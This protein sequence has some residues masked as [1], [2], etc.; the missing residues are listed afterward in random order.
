MMPVCTF[1]G[2]RDCPET[3][4]DKL[5]KALVELIEAEGVDVFYV[6]NHGAFDAMV[7]RQLREL[8]RC[9]PHIRYAVVLA[10]LPRKRYVTEEADLQDTMLPEG[11]EAVPQKFAIVWR[12]KWMLC[13]SDFVVTYVTHTWGSAAQ[14]AAMAARQNR[15]IIPL[16]Q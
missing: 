12:N 2:H 11:I 3:I 1:F 14:F 4:R 13:R 9:Y 7:R 5:R 8:A 16:A 10:Y 6:G 15:R